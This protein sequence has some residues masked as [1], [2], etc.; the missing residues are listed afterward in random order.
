[1][2]ICTAGSTRTDRYFLIHGYIF[3]NV[4]RCENLKERMTYLTYTH[5][6]F[7]CFPCDIYILQI[8][9]YPVDKTLSAI[10]NAFPPFVSPDITLEIHDS[11]VDPERMGSVV[12]E[13][14]IT[15][16]Y[17]PSGDGCD[18]EDPLGMALAIPSD[19]GSRIIVGMCLSRITGKHPNGGRAPVQYRLAFLDGEGWVGDINEVKRL[20][21][22]F[23]D[24]PGLVPIVVEV[25]G[26]VMK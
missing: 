19:D 7:Y 16:R 14:K 3:R 26:V 20:R 8:H 17:R 18:F 25:R 4:D 10:R 1:M 9:D 22:L 11:S 2:G 6:L 23:L 24:T 15:V 21:Q 12:T 5:D 13:G